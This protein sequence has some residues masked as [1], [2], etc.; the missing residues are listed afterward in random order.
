MNY[1][2]LVE[3]AEWLDGQGLIPSEKDDGDVGA[4]GLVEIYRESRRPPPPVCSKCGKPE[5]ESQWG[6]L[7]DVRVQTTW[8]EEGHADVLQLLCDVCW[9][10]VVAELHRLGFVDHRHGGINFLE[11]EECPGYA[12]MDACPRPSEYGEYIVQPWG[13]GH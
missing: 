4:R 5:A 9:E 7:F 10:P 3:F 11:D 6:R 12:N 1:R 2:E 8:Q 13:T